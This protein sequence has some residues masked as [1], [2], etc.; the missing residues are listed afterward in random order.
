MNRP[1][2]RKQKKTKQQIDNVSSSDCETDRASITCIDSEDRP[3][4]APS[5]TNVSSDDHI[6]NVLWKTWNSIFESKVD[7]E[8]V[9]SF[10]GGKI[11]HLFIGRLTR[12][13]RVGS[14]GLHAIEY[15][16]LKEKIGP[17]D[18]LMENETQ[19]HDIV[20]IEDVPVL[21][22][23]LETSYESKCKWRVQHYKEVKNF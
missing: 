22:G 2:S 3:T 18:L 15:V 14:V 10:I 4:I 7:E 13:C 17:G 12:R 5:H 16:C 1:T 21:M 11:P 19:E 9:I 6:Q 20:A 8:I 23:P